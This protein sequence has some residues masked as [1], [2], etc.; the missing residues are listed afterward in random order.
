MTAVYVHRQS[1]VLTKSEM[2]INIEKRLDGLTAHPQAV[3]DKIN[4]KLLE[5]GIMPKITRRKG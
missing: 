5:R 4:R 2:E 3:V 1:W